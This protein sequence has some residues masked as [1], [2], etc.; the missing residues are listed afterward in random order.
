[1]AVITV[2]TAQVGRHQLRIEHRNLMSR[3]FVLDGSTDRKG[4]AVFMELPRSY[5]T[6]RGAK[7]AASRLMGERLEWVHVD[8]ATELPKMIVQ[9]QSAP[10]PQLPALRHNPVGALEPSD[11]LEQLRADARRYRWLRERHVRIQGGVTWRQ[12]EGLDARVD[13]GL[14]HVVSEQ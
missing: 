4:T 6:L 11:D 8:D 14:D 2:F 10:E 7:Q 3:P 9:P 5:E 13:E 1:M 12:G